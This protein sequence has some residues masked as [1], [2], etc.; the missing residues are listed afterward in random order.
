MYDQPLTLLKG[1][2]EKKAQKFKKLGLETFNDVLYDFPRRYIDRR[3][4]RHVGDVQPETLG[5][6][7]AKVVRKRTKYI[8][9]TKKDMLILDV[10]E[11]YFTGEI[12]FFNAKYILD[13]FQEAKTYFFHGKIEKNGPVFKM[14]Q[15][16]YSDVSN[17]S[18]L[19][20]IPVYSSTLGVSQ[21]ELVDV[22]KQV[23]SFLFKRIDETL[24]SALLKLAELAPLEW[25]LNEIHF[26]TSVENY[27]KAKHRIVYDE[28]F[29]L[30][31]RLV[32][33]KKDYHRPMKNPFKL[34]DRIFDDIRNLP[35]QLTES[36]QQVL[37]DI[38]KDLTSTYSMNRL[39]QG[40][41]G[42]GKT[43]VAF[44][45]LMQAIYN[46]TQGILLAPTTLL[47]EQHYENFKKLFP[48]TT[49]V[50]L[51][52]NQTASEKK[53]LKLGIA[54][55][56]TKVIIGTHAIIQED[57]VMH[58][59]GV[60]ITDEQHRFG[61]R[62]R[63]SALQKA[64]NPH[65]LIMSATPIPRTLS[66]ILYGDMDIS[67]I[68]QMP[69]G[70]KPIK[71]HFVMSKKQNEMHQFI[72]EKLAEGKQAY[73]VCPLI[74]ASEEI[75]LHAAEAIYEQLK[76]KY[77]PFQVALIHGK[78]N[79]VDKEKT[80]QAFK[81]G[82]IS[83]LVSTTVIEVGIHVSN[84][85]IMVIMNTERFGLSQLHQLRGRVG[86]GDDQSYCFLLSDKL[87]VT[88]KQRVETLVNSNDGFEVAEKDLELRGPGEIFGLRQHG[89]PELKLA[90][91]VK[92]KDVIAIV[93][94][95]IKMVLEE[96]NMHNK[97]F[98]ELVYR[99]KS[100]LDKWFTL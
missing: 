25:A 44:L 32:L 18:F 13:D 24:P 31:L 70:R 7:A 93:Q 86:R 62:Q 36:Q 17:K 76:M 41:V 73:V 29:F 37:D 99:Q 57:V 16:E 95:H 64:E 68:N 49:C 3:E 96:F 14:M 63:L 48:N 11:G 92:H 88:A 77:A 6:I 23:L 9:K 21:R 1:V 69:Q 78:M 50:L 33:L 15:P 38:F 43:I 28:L 72:L 51:T 46:D 66:L 85:T 42:S 27:K 81:K 35:F 47:A 4:V 22:H 19:G 2:G 30:Q 82:D 53:K 12:V 40:D 45:T 83:V 97:A 91:L 80:M 87:S 94:K 67:V 58:K 84:A 39:V 98:E 75:D 89:I 74:E 71:T 8:A 55:G 60:V 5:L 61:I 10:Q 52:S 79:K 59:L 54:S 26:P 65:A 56:E 90:N 34:D 20:V 100:D